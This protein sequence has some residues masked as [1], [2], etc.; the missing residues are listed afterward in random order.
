[1][2][3]GNPGYKSNAHLLL[4]GEAFIAALLGNGFSFDRLNLDRAG[5][6]A[7]SYRN[8]IES[9]SPAL[10]DSD[11]EILKITLNRDS[12][13]DRL[14][15]G[16]FHQPRAIGGKTTV[17]QMVGEHRRLRDEEKAARKF[18]QPLEHELFRYSVLIEQEEGDFLSGMLSGNLDS[19]YARFWNLEADLPPHL[20]TGLTRMMPWAYIIKGNPQVCAKA[21]SIILGKPVSVVVVINEQQYQQDSYRLG[22]GALGIETLSGNSFD[23]P[24]VSWQFSVAGLDASE[25]ETLIGNTKHARFLQQFI[26]IFIPLEADA[27]FVYEVSSSGNEIADGILGYNFIL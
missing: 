22:E 26:D 5:S 8:D 16:L 14:P 11:Q 10:D 27:T 20:S 4:R 7:K 25:M 2:N 23:E 6:F 18:F 19:A 13:Y 15:E 17:G 1:M 3:T 12:I 24:S 21:L 9:V